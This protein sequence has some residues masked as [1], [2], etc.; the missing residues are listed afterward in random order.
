MKMKILDISDV[1]KWAGSRT[2]PISVYTITLAI[3]SRDV[4]ATCHFNGFSLT[5]DHT[6]KDW[7]E[8]RH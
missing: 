5:Y 3:I 2:H 6:T 4:A 7:I 8:T 1:W